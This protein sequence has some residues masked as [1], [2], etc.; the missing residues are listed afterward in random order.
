MELKLFNTLGRTLQVFKPR[1]DKKV[2]M[3]TCGPTVYSTSHI[4]NLR[5]YIFEDI[6][7][8]TLEFNGYQV[9]HVMNVTDVGHL[10]S[11]AD[12]GEDKIEKA[13]K[14][15]QRSA[16]DIAREHEAEFFHDL[17]LLNIEH[18]TKVI[19]ATE[20]IDWQIDL[21]KK[22][23][24]KGATYVTSDGVYFDTSKFPRYGELSGQKLTDK[25]AGARVDVNS[26]KHHPSD[27]ALWKFS[28]PEDKRQMEWPSPWG[29]GFPGWHIECSA[30]SMHELGDQFDIHCGGVDHIAVHHENEIAQSEAATG[31][32]PWVN[33]WIHG[34]FLVVGSP[35]QI[36]GI[37][38]KCP[39]CGMLTPIT[40]NP[41]PRTTCLKCG[42]VFSQVNI[43]MS[44]SSKGGVTT[45]D[46]LAKRFDP[47]AFR[48]LC[49]QSHYR[50]P[51]N[52]SLEAMEAAQNG[53]LRAW[54]MLADENNFKYGGDS[55]W[56]KKYESDFVNSINDDLNSSIAVAL[57]IELVN[58]VE[59][60][61]GAT[62]LLVRMN[63]VLALDLTPE[64]AGKHVKAIGSGHDA[65]LV[66]YT[67]A[68]TEKRYADSDAIR[69]QFEEIGIIVEDTPTGSR[70][71]RK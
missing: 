31:K 18:P 23:E 3:Y 60:T 8:R 59:E 6:L 36:T 34:E 21:I 40:D 51:L 4:G 53:L 64:L 11:D 45:L 67:K 28:K 20:T 43:K 50:K 56:L 55:E 70:L 57:A 47:L 39:N 46:N 69:K 25:K 37:Q 42:K 62:E 17:D 7:R 26:E 49:L 65:L 29:T 13:A 33:Y 16:L 48:Y 68:R 24:K 58:Y 63:D 41:A 54:N 14:S 35:F 27:F 2:G 30:M 9:D 22:L 12:E 71:R 32:H 61:P 66:E 5:T 15:A 1:H 52:F 38:N 19:R 10:T 44:K